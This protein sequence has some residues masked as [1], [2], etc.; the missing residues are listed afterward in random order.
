MWRTTMAAKYE[1]SMNC[2]ETYIGIWKK[3]QIRNTYEFIDIEEYG[4]P[5]SNIWGCQL[6]TSMGIIHMCVQFQDLLA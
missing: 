5:L 3:K 1:M 4:L 2:S 6:N